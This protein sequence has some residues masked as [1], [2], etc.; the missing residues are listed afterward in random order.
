ME[1]SFGRASLDGETLDPELRRHTDLFNQGLRDGARVLL[2]YIQG[3][4]AIKAGLIAQERDA[5]IAWVETVGPR[6][7]AIL[8]NLAAV[9]MV[10]VLEDYVETVTEWLRSRNATFNARCCTFEQ[11]EV[12]HLAQLT[13][14]SGKAAWL[15]HLRRLYDLE[16]NASLDDALLDLCCQRTGAAHEL[17]R[18]EH[19]AFGKHH[20]IWLLACF[21]LIN[22]IALSAQGRLE[23]E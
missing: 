19:M 6:S 21:T 9:Q 20:K 16:E 18:H 8:S 14:P 4:E 15:K 23:L 13:K 3:F 10:A 1:E 12:K 2:V 22:Q 11:A 7:P 5:L 17:A